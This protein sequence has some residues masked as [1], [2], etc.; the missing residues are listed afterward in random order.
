MR[1]STK[2]ISKLFSITVVLAPVCWLVL[3]A[4][5]RSAAS[6]PFVVRSAAVERGVLTAQLDWQPSAVLLDALDHGIALDFEITLKAD[7]PNELG[8]QRT[9]AQ[10]H[11]H[12]E[13]R[14][15]PLTR[16]YQLRD[17]D[18]VPGTA[19]ETRSYAARASLIA[20]IAD[21]RL[22]LPATFPTTAAQ[23]Y[24]LRIE[25]ERDNLPGALRLPALFDADWRLS[26]GNYVWNP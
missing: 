22:E 18:P 14:Y 2:L 23:H 6:P 4:C 11:W 8:W 5:A 20:A 1:L 24:S 15:F 19:A 12:R 9:F 17:L 25:L 26:S 3:G 10:T 21:L 16:Q 7:A 13:L